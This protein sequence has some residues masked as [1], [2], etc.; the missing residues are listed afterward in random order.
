[1]AYEEGL[2]DQPFRE[3]PACFSFPVDS[4]EQHAGRRLCSDHQGHDKRIPLSSELLVHY[5]WTAASGEFNHPGKTPVHPSSVIPAHQRLEGGKEQGG[6]HE[7][8]LFLYNPAKNRQ[9]VL[10]IPGVG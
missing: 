5:N 9:R 4:L 6:K 8:L 10:I 1:M 3:Q 7:A 2:Y